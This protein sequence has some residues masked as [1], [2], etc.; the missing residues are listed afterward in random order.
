[1]QTLSWSENIS[2]VLAMSSYMASYICPSNHQKLLSQVKL[3]LLNNMLNEQNNPTKLC[4]ASFDHLESLCRSAD[5]YLPT[6]IKHLISHK[7]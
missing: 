6:Q 7:A 1:M 2:Y 5:K 4:E 3:C